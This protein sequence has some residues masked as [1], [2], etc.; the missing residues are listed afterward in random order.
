MNGSKVLVSLETV[1]ALLADPIWRERA[2]NV[3][4]TRALKQLL[5]DYCTANGKLVTIDEDLTCLYPPSSRQPRREPTDPAS[6]PP[7]R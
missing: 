3:K 1:C 5:L 4:T 7:A 6:S 2:R